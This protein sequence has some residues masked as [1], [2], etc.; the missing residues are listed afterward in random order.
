[1]DD[2]KTTT[3]TQSTASEQRAKPTDQEQRILNAQEQ[4]FMQSVPGQER[5]AELIPQTVEG[6]LSGG[7][8]LPDIYNSL[9]AG[10]SPEITNEL[11]GEAVSDIMP[12]FQSSGILDSGVAASVAARTAGDIRRNVAENNLQRIY[13]LL[14]LGLGQG[15][16]QQSV[17]SGQGTALGGQLAG[18]RTVTSTGT[19]SGMTTTTQMNPFLKSFQTSFGE[20]MGG[21]ATG[22][23]SGG[24][25]YLGK[26]F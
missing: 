25:S 9:F 26:L 2:K 24:A 4:I 17:G 23:V 8:G 19:G 1:M 7:K 14:G 6:I 15:L 18:L 16:A 21:L 12:G 5:L 11:A 20:G 3:E 13:N 10:I 22:G